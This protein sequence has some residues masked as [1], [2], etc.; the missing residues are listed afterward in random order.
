MTIENKLLVV[1]AGPTA[2]GKTSTGIFLAH[3]YNSEIISADSRQFYKELIIGTASPTV[4]E[5][6]LATHHFVHHISISEQFNVSLFET[7]VLELAEKQFQERNILFMVGGSGLYINAVCH[8]IDQLPDPD[9]DIRQRLKKTL[10]E[11][12]ITALQHEL[13]ALD[14]VYSNQV[15]LSNPARLM[16]AI[17]ICRSTG[18][19]Y[20]S[21]RTNKPGQRNFKIL[22]VG[23]ELPREMLY[24]RINRR[25]DAMMEA[26]LF[27]EALSLYPYRHFNALNTVG[28]KELFDHFEGLTTLE[29]AVDKIKVHSRRYAKRQLTWF[30]KDTEYKWYRPDQLD[31]IIELIESA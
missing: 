18:V 8:G 21:L 1:I 29:H 27:E 19:P 11:S 28:Y 20:S 10:A 22:K 24:D 16:R 23:L 4:E 14:P 5:L 26:G 30:K 12:G 6:S 7:G 31:Q 17:E 25:V 15:D 3:H 2:V 9:P 13:A